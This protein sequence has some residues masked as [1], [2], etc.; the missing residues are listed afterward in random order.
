MFAILVCGGWEPREGSRATQ[1]G[2]R[3]S[4]TGGAIHT[5]GAGG[6]GDEIRQAEGGSKEAAVLD[7]TIYSGQF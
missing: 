5:Q 1:A 2:S 3:L 4:E 7:V 6:D